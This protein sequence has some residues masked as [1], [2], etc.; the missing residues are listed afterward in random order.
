MGAPPIDLRNHRCQIVFLPFGV[1][2]FERA[3]A[4]ARDVDGDGAAGG[5]VQELALLEVREQAALGVALAVAHIKARGDFFA[6]D[7]AGFG[8]IQRRR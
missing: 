2:L 8:H 3:Q 6:G 7:N 5:R 1:P 4:A